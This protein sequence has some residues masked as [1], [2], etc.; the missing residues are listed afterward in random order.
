MTQVLESAINPPR[1]SKW[2][3]YVICGV[4][5]RRGGKVS[6]LGRE[7]RMLTAIMGCFLGHVAAGYTQAPSFLE[8]F[9]ESY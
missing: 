3:H 9:G 4:V 5:I 6:C 8:P 2:Y 1:P 7:L